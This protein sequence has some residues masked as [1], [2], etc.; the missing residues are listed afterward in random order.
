MFRQILTSLLFILIISGSGNAQ[1][2][3]TAITKNDVSNFIASYPAI[4][5]DFEKLGIKYHSTG[6]EFT[7]PE[8]FKALDEVNRIV[9]KHGYTDY[10]EYF[11]KAGIILTTYAAIKME[12]EGTSLQP[13][14]QKA[15]EEIKNNSYYTAEQKEQMIEAIRQSGAAISEA[16]KSMADSENIQAVKPFMEEIERILDAD[17]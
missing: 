10:T 16:A 4:K 2:E 12:I 1:D 8:G 17:Q 5:T 14:I 9:A 7:I 13:E 15:I 3:V 11:S 6:D